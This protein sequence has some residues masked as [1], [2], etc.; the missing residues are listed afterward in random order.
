MIIIADNLQIT[1]PIVERAL[2]EMNPSPI[3]ALVRECVKAGADAIDVNSGPLSR[4]GD[5][6]MR[7]LVNAVQ[8]VT[9]LPLFIDTANPAAME[10]GLTACNKKPVMNGFSLEPRKLEKFLPLAHHLDCDVIG[11]LLHPDGLVPKTGEDRLDVAV[12]LFEARKEP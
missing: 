2:D 8:E 4:Q 10:A 11:Y 1:D 9:D 3:Q 5:V 7:F 6:K 12:Q